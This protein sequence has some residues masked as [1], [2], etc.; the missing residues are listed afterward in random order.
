LLLNPERTI[1]QS[2]ADTLDFN[3][4]KIIIR[5]NLAWI[6]LIILLTN[7]IAYFYLRYTKDQYESVSEIKLD[8]KQD[9]QELGIRELVPE[10]QNV[11]IISAEIETIKSK[12]FL[13]SVIDSLNLHVSYF[14]I[15]KILNTEL[16]TSSP[17]V[18]RP[19]IT[20]PFYYDSPFL[21]E[22]TSGNAFELRIPAYG[23]T[24]TGEFGKPV[25]TDDF[26][27]I[28]EKKGTPA[29]EPNNKYS[30]VINSRQA[31]LDYMLTNLTVEPINVNANTIRVSFR[32]SNPFKAQ[33]LVNGIDSL[34]LRYS[35]AQKNLAN[36]QKITWLNNEL[37]QIEQQME[38]FED[39]F[40]NFTL[41]NKTSNLDDELKRTISL[42]NK[43]DSQRYETSRRI[44]EINRLLDNLSASVFL[45]GPAYRGF[46]P[47]NLSKNIEK[48]QEIYLDMDKM[49]LSYSE[50]TLAFRQREAETENLRKKVFSG[51]TE[52]KSDLLKR[53]QELNKSKVS[54]ESEFAGIPD[55]S[56][57]F[58]KKNRYYKLYEELYLTLMQRKSEF[59]IAKAGSTPDF[60]IL[61]T[62]DLPQKPIAPQR[63][64]I[65]I[66]GFTGGIILSF[67]FVGILYLANDR[68]TNAY[69]VERS[70]GVPLLGVVPAFR[71]S[72]E[73]GVYIVNHPK[74]MVSEAI[75][76]LR[77]NLD[78][79]STA[80]AKKIIAIS[81]TVSGE[82][83]SFLAVNLGGIVALSRKKVVLLDLDM[84]KPKSNLPANGSNP[85]KGIST[86]LIRKNTWQ[87]CLL[88]TSIENFDFIP[89][90]PHPPNPSELLLN[91]EFTSLLNNLKEQYDFIILDTPPVGLVTDGIMAMKHADV[92]VY[93]FRANYSK[94]EFI[95][96][97]HR[98]VNIN[99]FTNITAVVNALPAT[100]ETA[101]GYGYYED[102]R[103]NRFTSFFKRS[104]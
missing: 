101:Y 61:S 27:F 78:F 2:S 30:F 90:G 46:L 39:Y 52:I 29:F 34:Y 9:A 22:P 53:L 82:G 40:E 15:G 32:D 94:K 92:S 35:N 28:I 23:K 68:I 70:A 81:S 17:F 95:H 73:T 84:R 91:G 33:D 80:S 66:L 93:V 7:A 86:I 31:L 69:E 51:L 43:I 12:L 21:I 72:A 5:T 3:K 60:K 18:V 100:S 14:S 48:L 57:Q 59:E 4:L 103:P 97:L 41:K 88:T 63:L 13:S 19:R 20:N 83:K 44:S 71:G 47:E 75:R 64:L 98:I 26:L 79:F 104:V 49:K 62:A 55:K 24:L 96:N 56:T 67:L 74:S 89:S 25:A 36:L 87:E 38:Q 11:N 16:H 58:N 77:T 1:A 45:P 6:A 37:S 76:T 65:Y 54:L 10:R 42:I 50:N 85:D 99:K 8:V 102:R